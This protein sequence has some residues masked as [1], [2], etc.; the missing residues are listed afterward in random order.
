MRV[1]LLDWA[2]KPPRWLQP[3]AGAAEQSGYT[4]IGS[5]TGIT[6]AE[7]AVEADRYAQIGH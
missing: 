6:S 5:F 7:R 1:Y 2:G 3:I 4:A